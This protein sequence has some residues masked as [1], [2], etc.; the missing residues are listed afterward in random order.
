MA[1]DR[2]LFPPKQYSSNIGSDINSLYIYFLYTVYAVYTVYTVYTVLVYIY[3]PLKF[4]SKIGMKHGWQLAVKKRSNRWKSILFRPQLL[5]QLSLMQISEPRHWL[6]A[7]QELES[8]G[9]LSSS[10]AAAASRHRDS[11]N[12]KN[13]LHSNGFGR[14]LQIVMFFIR[15]GPIACY[16]VVNVI[17]LILLFVH[18]VVVFF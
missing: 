10:F 12:L 6:L 18:A 3:I 16:M 15:G 11:K 13:H 17:L 14:F 5:E 7:A 8:Q 9:R 2:G 1:L 4:R